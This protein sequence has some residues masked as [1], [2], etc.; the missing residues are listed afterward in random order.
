MAKR[1]VALDEGRLVLNPSRDEKAELLR[2]EDADL[3]AMSYGFNN[4]DE[5]KAEGERLERE[6]LAAVFN[7]GADE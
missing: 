7:K 6:R 5:L 3:W 2:S 1:V 4:A